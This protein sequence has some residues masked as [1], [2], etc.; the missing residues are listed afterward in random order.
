VSDRIRV[1]R[2]RSPFAQVPVALARDHALSATAIRLWLVLATYVE[3]GGGDPT[4]YPYRR[5]I[6]EHMGC[7][8]PTVARSLRELSDAGYLVVRSGKTAGVTNTYELID[9]PAHPEGCIADDPGGGSPVIQGVDHGRSTRE[10]EPNTESQGTTNGSGTLPDHEFDTFWTAYPRRNGK[11]LGRS[12]TET[13]WR[14]LS[15]DDRAA[16]LVGVVHY[17]AACDSGMTLAKDPERWLRGRCWEDW[18]EPA[19]PEGRRPSRAAGAEA[20]VEDLFA[21]R[22]R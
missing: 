13:R 7:S 11:R 2:K 16:A 15:A 3:W 4:A 12:I 22:R 20:V 19:V 17:A 14:R 10:R 9:D 18:Q 21:G 8:I 6:A 5:T 1:S